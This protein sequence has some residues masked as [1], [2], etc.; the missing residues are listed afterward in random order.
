MDRKAFR[1]E[2]D[3]GLFQLPGQPMMAVEVDLQ[4]KRG[5]GGHPHIAQAEDSS[6]K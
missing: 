5:P 2:G 4:A 1:P 3:T 6:M